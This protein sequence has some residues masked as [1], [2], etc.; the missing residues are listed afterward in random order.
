MHQKRGYALQNLGTMIIIFVLIEQNVSIPSEH[1][2]D[3]VCEQNNLYQFK[4]IHYSS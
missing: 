4:I 3:F 1:I 2:S